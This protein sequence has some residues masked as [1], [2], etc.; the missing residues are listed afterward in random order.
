MN[1]WVLRREIIRWG[2]LVG[3]TCAKIRI[4]VRFLPE[5]GAIAAP[6]QATNDW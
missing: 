2:R 5:S 4:F 3:E 1:I 6:G